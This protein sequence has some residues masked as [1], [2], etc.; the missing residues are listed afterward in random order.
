MS[1]TKIMREHT[2]LLGAKELPRRKANLAENVDNP[3]T[4]GFSSLR[5]AFFYF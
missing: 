4:L 2:E 5:L 1:V 3:A